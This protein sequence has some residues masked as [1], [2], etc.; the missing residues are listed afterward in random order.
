MTK[1]Y[2][3]KGDSYVRSDVGEDAAEVGYPKP[4]SDGWSGLD[5]TAIE[6]GIDC[7]LDL[8]GGSACFFKGSQCLHVDQGAN[9]VTGSVRAIAE[10]WPGLDAM[11]FADLNNRPGNLTPGGPPVGEIPGK[12]Q[13]AQ[14]SDLPD[15]PSRLRGDSGLPPGERLRSAWHWRSHPSVRAEGRRHH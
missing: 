15:A 4:L 2:L 11:G 7:V 14:L 6:G 3:I 9:A 1:A 5:G 13:L 12:A 10:D 8:G